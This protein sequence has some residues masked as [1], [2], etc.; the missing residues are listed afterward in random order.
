MQE[1]SFK[2][3]IFRS[4]WIDFSLLNVL[5]SSIDTPINEIVLK[6]VFFVFRVL[7]TDR[8]TFGPFYHFFGLFPTLRARNSREHGLKI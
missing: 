1:N 6:F 7:K 8:K 5:V 3:T 2:E 4:I